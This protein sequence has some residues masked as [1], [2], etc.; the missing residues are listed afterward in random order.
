MTSFSPA[1]FTAVKA[2]LH[3]GCA[4]LTCAAILGLVVPAPASAQVTGNVYDSI[5][6]ITTDSMTNT[7]QVTVGQN[8]TVIRWTPA[9][10]GPFI[11]AGNSLN[12]GASTAVN[13][14]Y[15][16][17]NQFVDSSGTEYG[18]PISINGTVTSSANGNIWFQNGAGIYIGQAGR[19]DVGSLVLTSRDIQHNL[20]AI[21][22]TTIG[23]LYGT[24]GEIQF[25]GIRTSTA[26]NDGIIDNR[27]TINATSNYVAIVAPNIVQAGMVTANGSI[28]YVVA[29]AA[30]I[31]IN[32]GLFDI[33]VTT[34]SGT[35]NSILLTHSGQSLVNASDP[36]QNIYMVAVPKNNAISMLVQ[37]NIGFGADTA[38]VGSNGSII[39][40]A[41][42]NIVGGQ[43]DTS[44]PAQPS[45]TIRIE[46][47]AGGTTRFNGQVTAHA[48]GTVFS[49]VGAGSTLGFANDAT[50][51][52]DENLTVSV[53][54]RLEMGY[55]GSANPANLTL[56]SGGATTAGQ[57]SLRATGG[58]VQLD[59][60]LTLNGDS[61]RLIGPGTWVTG[62]AVNLEASNNGQIL[63][64]ANT[65]VTLS[66]NALDP[67]SGTAGL[68][69]NAGYMVVQANSGG[70]LDLNTIIANANVDTL[71]P[72]V[73]Q[74]NP[75]SIYFYADNGTIR[76]N[77]ITANKLGSSSFTNFE[78]I[79]FRATGTGRIISTGSITANTYANVEFRLNGTAD[80]M[81]SAQNSLTVNAGGLI[82]I[83]HSGRAAGTNSL[84]GGLVEFST[85]DRI[86]S[87][88]DSKILA[89]ERLDL[90]GGSGIDIG[91]AQS[92]ARTTLYAED[93]DVAVDNLLS[94]GDVNVIGRS[95]DI[96]STDGLS[97]DNIDAYEGDATIRVANT[98]GISGSA[99][100]QANMTLTSADI[101]IDTSNAFV[102]GG[103][104]RLINGNSANTTKVGGTSG[105]N[106][107]HLSS[108]ELNSIRADHIFIEAPASAANASP[109]ILVDD[110][111]YGFGDIGTLSIISGGDLSVVGDVYIGAEN[112]DV[113]L[114]LSAGREMRILLDQG[115]IA[116]SNGSGSSVPTGTLRLSAP[117]II[118]ATQ[119]AIND[120]ATA[121]TQRQ[122]E[123]RLMD[124]DGFVSSGYI[125]AN[126]ITADVDTGFFVQNSGDG[127]TTD[128]RTGLLFGGGG[129][130]INTSNPNALIVI[131]GILSTFN[132]TLTGAEVITGRSD[133]ITGITINGERYRDATGFDAI[134]LMNGC[135]IVDPTVCGAAAL[136]PDTPTTTNLPEFP[137]QVIIGD[138]TSPDNEPEDEVI[139]EERESAKAPDSLISVSDI[140]PMS[141]EPLI[142]DPVTGAANDDLWT[143]T[144]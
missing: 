38:T 134:S 5:G 107:Y 53:S 60:D 31:R 1:R 83:N 58:T 119:S 6:T 96:V 80:N 32:Q 11:E 142:I 86:I 33:D 30:S 141:G 112:N 20:E 46:T 98:L 108:D 34:G 59:G 23:S 135:L 115:S 102:E 14:N 74:N 91:E 109:Q 106:D 21:S 52:G 16:V 70:L 61:S 40:S 50:L 73:T 137:I 92:Q 67:S 48:S 85:G 42:R 84:S 19:F 45:S 66:S 113:T 41:G 133:A 68:A 94:A 110:M 36:N 15:T 99:R 22:G 116:M 25:G 63:S 129:L 47:A 87:N 72:S 79:R 18:L 144:P 39:L 105:G 132:A 124:S 17:L 90:F 127:D 27:G 54:G 9:G 139:A 44:S 117:R 130:N 104:V 89:T 125:A 8:E 24:N 43:I 120:L 65:Q 123:Q 10:S 81:I 13:G 136:G 62:S 126:R 12:F 138:P 37:G 28:A 82:D 140:H 76:S 97:F 71:D 49:Q 128:A 7:S 3:G 4:A 55:S 122:Y 78:G 101:E 69:M 100:A 118:A 114:E 75:G 77:D 35:L 64:G 57:V 111:S 2:M 143:P 121:T 29:E 26:V 95:I 93:G 88:A 131:N 56:A 51:T 103:N